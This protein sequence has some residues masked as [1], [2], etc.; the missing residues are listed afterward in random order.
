MKAYQLTLESENTEDEVPLLQLGKGQAAPNI[1]DIK[2]ND[3]TVT[4][5]ANTGAAVSVM[6]HQQ[7][8]NLLP[9][10]QLLP[11]QVVLR[12]C[13][14]KEVA[15]AVVLPVQVAH[16]GHEHDLSLAIVQG[17]GSAF[18]GQERLSKIRLSLLSIV[19]HM[20][21]SKRLDVWNQLKEVFCSTTV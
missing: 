17:I 10:A 20:V 7:K 12:T 18:C 11:S 14:L 13:T 5:E 9:Q 15:V 4:Q 6:S 16:E 3:I 1:V 8:R 19:F 21:V 2:V